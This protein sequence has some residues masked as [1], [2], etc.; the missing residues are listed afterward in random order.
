MTFPGKGCSVSGSR[1]AADE[2]EKSPLRSAW[3]GTVEY[4]FEKLLERLPE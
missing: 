3:F 4:A 2:A 1:M